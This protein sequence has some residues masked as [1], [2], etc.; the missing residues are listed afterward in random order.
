MAHWRESSA[1]RY[2]SESLPLLEYLRVEDIGGAIGIQFV[3]GQVIV[4]RRELRVAA[5]RCGICGWNHIEV[6]IGLCC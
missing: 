4:K 6:K 1:W 3:M 2:L 5:Q